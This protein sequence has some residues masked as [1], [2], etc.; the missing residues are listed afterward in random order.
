METSLLVSN[1]A[2]N[3]LRIVTLTTSHNRCEK[4]IQ[5]LEDLHNQ[6]GI[7]QIELIHV[8]VDDD[9]CDQT[10]EMVACKFPDVNILKGTGQLYW[11]GGMRFGWEEMVKKINLDYLLVYNDDVRLHNDA[12]SQLIQTKIDFEKVHETREVTIVGGFLDSN[13]LTSY[14]GLVRKHSYAPIKLE[15]I[16]LPTKNSILVDAMNMNACLISNGALKKIGFISKHYAHSRADYDYGLRL[17]KAGGLNLLC[18]NPIGTC[19]R[20]SSDNLDISQTI[21]KAY[22]NEFSVKKGT[23]KERVFYYRSHAGLYGVAL[24]ISYYFIFFPIKHIYKK[25]IH[26]IMHMVQ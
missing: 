13:G 14:G 9:S 4:T 16:E 15:R 25:F 7:D 12:I 20:N 24:V 5:A 10:S 23:L 21:L 11:A 22:K 1:L 18:S 17:T 3:N 6:I 8:L 2:K 19:D 26:K